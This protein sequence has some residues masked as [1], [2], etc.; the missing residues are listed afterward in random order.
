MDHFK[1]ALH[2]LDPETV[3]SMVSEEYKRLDDLR[4]KGEL[5]D[6]GYIRS[7]QIRATVNVFCKVMNKLVNIYQK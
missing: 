2:Y 3:T 7:C 1:D 5:K 4:R 6:F